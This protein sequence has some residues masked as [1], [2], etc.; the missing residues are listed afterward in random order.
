[1]SGACST[2]SAPLVSFADVQE[3]C[4]ASSELTPFLELVAHDD[5]G[6]R[7]VHRSRECASL[8]AG[9]YPFS[10]GHGGGPPCYYAIYTDDPLRWLMESE[11][12]SARIRAQQEDR[13]FY[14][15]LGPESGHKL[16]KWE[17][18]RRKHIV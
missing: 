16:C 10:E 9:E 8:W 18:Y 3:R 1:M 11:D 15:S 12:L 6:W 2:Y 5:S 13:D 17:G 7:S 14:E 4:R